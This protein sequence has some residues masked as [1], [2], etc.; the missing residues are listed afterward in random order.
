MR[1]TR[2]QRQVSGFTL[3][4]ALLFS[5][6]SYAAW[7]DFA[8]QKGVPEISELSFGKV[9]LTYLPD[10]YQLGSDKL[11][12]NALV[13]RGLAEISEGRIGVVMV[14]VD[15]GKKWDKAQLDSSGAFNYEFT[16][17]FEREYDFRIKAIATTGK[18][19]DPNAG[20]FLFIVTRI[21]NT[22]RA[23]QLFAQLLNFY[24]RENRSG[25]L[26][27]VSDDFEG[28]LSSL[29]DAIEDDFRYL[30]NIRISPTVTRVVEY[31]G[32]TEI[33]FT[34]DRTVLSQSTGKTLTDSAS[35]TMN[36]RDTGEGL[37][38]TGMAL[39]LIFGVSGGSEVATS[40]DDDSV[41]QDVLVVTETGETAVT[42]QQET[43]ADS[44]EVVSGTATLLCQRNDASTTSSTCQA[45]DISSQSVVNESPDNAQTGSMMTANFAAFMCQ[46]G[47]IDPIAGCTADGP[48][49]ST[50]SAGL[51]DL[52]IASIDSF[53]SVSSNEGDY[54][55]VA[56]EDE[57][58][59]A[60]D[61]GR[62]FA[63]RTDD[64]LYALIRI[65]SHTGNPGDPSS[66]SIT[67]QY[68]VQLNGTASF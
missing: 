49:I 1:T 18:G 29:E 50:S 60:G 17:Q 24:V 9:E 6:V 32:E 2:Y 43:V 39:P 64:V 7:Y 3:L 14:S 48:Y 59:F 55:E 54:D 44:T 25:F 41:G 63:V 10:I 58:H 26:S 33:S 35:S 23:K 5:Q 38:L 37:Q 42:E 46:F 13:I 8:S 19:S 30:D 47:G 51:N 52:G 11:E 40:V 56:A 57:T 53:S 20:A 45:F 28:D 22:E 34:Y 27:L 36:F 68:K 62:V 65:S 15:G 31:G 12:G 4:I 66:I 16:P 21:N 67:I 61:N